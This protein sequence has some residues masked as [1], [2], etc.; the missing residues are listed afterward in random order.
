MFYNVFLWEK[1]QFGK[2]TFKKRFLRIYFEN[3]LMTLLY[4]IHKMF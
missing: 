3:D 4:D 1:Y 2:F